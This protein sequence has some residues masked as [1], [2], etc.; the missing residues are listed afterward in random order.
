MFNVGFEFE[1]TTELDKNE[2][3]KLL[4]LNFPDWH[5]EIKIVKDF[6]VSGWELV[7]PPYPEELANARMLSVMKFI[8]LNPEFSTD[9][10]TAFH[11]NISFTDVTKNNQIGIDS[12]YAHTN[13][14]KVL[15]SFN[16]VRNTYCRSPKNYHFYSYIQFDNL[17][18]LVKFTTNDQYRTSRIDQLKKKL[19]K[20]LKGNTKNI[21]IADK[22]QKGLRYFE[23]RMIGG[24]NYH[25]KIRM[26]TNYI[27]HFKSALVLSTEKEKE[28]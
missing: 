12:V 18:E 14:T 17:D 26:I 16:R 22:R 4:K 28:Q 19:D 24:L 13:I 23:F 25:K 20:E 8:N 5:K 7:T 21:P 10:H 1:V 2:V 27:E 11:V 3:R 9:K 6:T 15:K